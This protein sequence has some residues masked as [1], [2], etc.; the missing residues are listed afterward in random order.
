[1]TSQFNNIQGNQN[2]QASHNHQGSHNQQPSSPYL[3]GGRSE[4]PGHFI[5]SVQYSQTP[6]QAWIP[7]SSQNYQP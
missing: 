7:S 2:Q 3:N 4:N 1:M 5:Q 6:N